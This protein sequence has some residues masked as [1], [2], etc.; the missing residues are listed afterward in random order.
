[1]KDFNYINQL[2]AK[3][4]PNTDW[5][6]N[7]CLKAIKDVY[8][9]G[10]P[11]TLWGS[12]AFYRQ[13]MPTRFYSP[14]IMT[15]HQRAIKTY[16]LRT[17][18]FVHT[19]VQVLYGKA[20]GCADKY[21]F[22]AHDFNGYFAANNFRQFGLDSAGHFMHLE[23]PNEVNTRLTEWLERFGHRTPPT[24]VDTFNYTTRTYCGNYPPPPFGGSAGPRATSSNQ[25]PAKS[26]DDL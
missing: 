6:N 4:S 22:E 23:S 18:E 11:H 10:H 12:L 20:D 2:W 9:H 26:S 16:N 25:D 13:N 3:W 7:P 19:P 5:T 1:M 24:D 21:G 15:M 14:S 8:R 17:K